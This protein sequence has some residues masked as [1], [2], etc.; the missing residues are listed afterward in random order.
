MS[1][2]SHRISGPCVIVRAHKST[3]VG[4]AGICNQVPSWKLWH[5][6]ALPVIAAREEF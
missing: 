3:V 1:A 2:K 5:L 6:S 4:M